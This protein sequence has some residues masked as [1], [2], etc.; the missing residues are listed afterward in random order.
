MA[1]LDISPAAEGHTLVVP[2]VHVRDLLDTP[3]DVARDVMATVRRVAIAL[4][5]TYA[6]D[7]VSVV[8]S[9]G[10]AAGQ[11]VFHSHVHLVP[12]RTG[13]GLTPRWRQQRAGDEHLAA[14]AARLRAR[15]HHGRSSAERA[16][17]VI[18]AYL[19]ERDR[20][21]DWEHVREGFYFVRIPGSARRHIPIELS[22]GQR[23]LRAVSY[24]S[25][26][27]EEM[28]ADAYRYLL[29]HNFAATGVAFSS[30]RDRAVAL[31]GRVDLHALTTQLLDELIG[32]IVDTTEAT[33][34]A[35]LR[36]GFASRFAEREPPQPGCF[37]CSVT[38]GVVAPP[39]GVVYE[40]GYWRVEHAVSPAP[41]AGW[42]IVKPLRHCLGIDELSEQ[43]AAS[44]GPLLAR[45]CEAVRA[46]TAALRV[47][48][49][50]FGEAVAHLHIHVIPRA[51]DLPDDLHGPSVFELLRT[52]AGRGVRDDEC[53]AIAARIRA[54]LF[55]PRGGG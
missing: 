40:D 31:V 47:Y 16:A 51:D 34:Q 3:E 49:A 33:F 19:R 32:K 35:F 21:L 26:E 52:A 17:D 30:D 12:R 2:R 5:E 48:T 13:D 14:A 36:I 50:F 1:F 42:L 38:A 10:E 53:A 43:E 44:L 15:A 55:V 24:F 23:T 4:R 18:E 11:D 37:A 54:R 46:E 45:T 41:M 22:I 20:S 7:S 29:Q 28:Q 25:I 27:P 39:G 6:T 8:Q 9:N